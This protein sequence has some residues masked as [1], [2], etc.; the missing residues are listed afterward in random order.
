M[1]PVPMMPIFMGFEVL[2][3][4]SAAEA[5]RDNIAAKMNARTVFMSTPAMGSCG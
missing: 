2:G 1:L 3:T 5:P 4:A